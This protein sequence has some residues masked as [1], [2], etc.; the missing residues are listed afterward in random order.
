MPA[1]RIAAGS[2][3]R[4]SQ[5]L[6]GLAPIE[7]K[8]ILAAAT[9]RRY[10]ANSI[11]TNQGQPA[12]QIFLLT[13]GLVRY[14]FVTDD[15]RKLL[16]Q[17]IGPGD[18]VGGRAILSIR[19]SYLASAEAVMDSN[20]W[21]W[22]RHSIRSLIARYPRL[23]E[24]ALL[25][26]SDYV[27]WHLMSHV[28]LACQSVRQRVAQVLTTLARTIGQETKAGVALHLTNEELANA[29]NVTPYTVSRLISQWHR[30]RAL[31]KRRGRVL[32]VSAERLHLRRM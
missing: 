7:R 15:G 1:S 8:E 4:G 3:V 17:W 18:L 21:V 26:A 14:F 16:F 31:V 19:S 24:N 23:L 2:T 9:Q 12:E 6:T 11:I 30:D 29:A 10:L 25:T 32:L 22:D 5:F 27:D 20:M 13:K 28:G